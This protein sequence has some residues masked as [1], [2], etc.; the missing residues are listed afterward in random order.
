V[1]QA[2][3][4]KF[5]LVWQKERRQQKEERKMNENKVSEGGERID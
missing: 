1:F 4:E 5:S 3:L 2:A